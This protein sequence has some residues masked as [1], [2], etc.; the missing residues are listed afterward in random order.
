MKKTFFF[1]FVLF[2]I[3]QLHAQTPDLLFSDG[4]NLYHFKQK[5]I[6]G[7]T[8]VKDLYQK[9]LRPNFSVVHKDTLPVSGDKHDYM[10]L[11]PYFW[12]GKEEDKYER[13]DGER[14][15]STQKISDD[16]EKEELRKNLQSLSLVYYLS[17]NEKYAAKATT[18]LRAWFIDDSTKMNPNFNYAQAVTGIN[19][20]RGTGLIEARTFAFMLDDI[21]LLQGSSSWTKNDDEALQKWYASFLSWMLNSKNGKHE[22]AAKNNHGTWYDV[23][24]VAISLFLHKEDWAKQYLQNTSF[25]RID[26]QFEQDGRQPLELARTKALDYSTFNLQ[27]WFALATLAD[28]TGIDLWHYHHDNK[29]IKQSFDCLLPYA[30]AE[31]EWPYK[32]IVPYKK[33]GFY[34]LLQQ[35][36][37]HYNEEQYQQHLQSLQSN[38]DD[39]V[40]NILLTAW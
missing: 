2:A 37:A 23:Q 32:Q 5:I 10:S 31:K 16:N 24:V 14:N 8:Q 21:Q 22:Q 7:N 33:R 27:A 3:I 26:T 25:K 11:A 17:G 9:L 35:A 34:Y 15:P 12:P 38:A 1:F 13:R 29:S 19:D 39:T 18:L 36:Q 20:G 28:K 40:L 4:N 30:S 6:Q